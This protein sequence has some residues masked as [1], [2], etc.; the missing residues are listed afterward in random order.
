MSHLVQIDQSHGYFKQCW[1]YVL[2][3]DPNGGDKRW[4]IAEAGLELNETT[5]PD[6]KFITTLDYGLGMIDFAIQGALSGASA[7]MAR[8]RSSRAPTVRATPAPKEKP[9]SNTGRSG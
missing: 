1:D 7:I 3:K 8:T 6:E 5:D 4:I 9:A 2:E